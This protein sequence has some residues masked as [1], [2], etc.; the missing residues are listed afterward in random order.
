MPLPQTDTPSPSA[1]P[2]KPA[3]SRVLD[4]ALDLVFPPRCVSCNS[5]DALICDRCRAEMVPADG[6]RCQTCWMPIDPKAD[7]RRCWARRPRLRA[8]R[9]AFVYEN[10]ARDAVL[11]L[12]FRGLS[13]VAPLLAQSMAEVLSDWRPPVESIVPVPLSGRRRRIRGYNQSELLAGE[14]SRLSGITLNRRALIRRRDTTAQA[15]T[16]G[17]ERWQN[18]ADAFRP[19]KGMPTGSV[20]LVDDVITTGATLE[21]C[22]RVLVSAGAAAVFAL[23]FARED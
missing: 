11:A 21:A 5:F 23:T 17:D 2:R 22:A 1:P 10:A 14:V 8:V 9:S 12:K 6:P 20:L 7:C 3:L 16:S 18:V 13:S 15:R 4:R 19:A